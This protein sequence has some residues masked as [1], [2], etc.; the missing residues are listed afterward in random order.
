MLRL[1]CI[2]FCFLTGC[3]A[4]SQLTPCSRAKAFFDAF[5]SMAGTSAETHALYY[6]ASGKDRFREF[7]DLID[8]YLDSLLARAGTKSFAL[9]WIVINPRLYS[10][11]LSKQ[12][13]C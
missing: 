9:W 5:P 10:A 6:N 1:L 13:P 11:L 7:N 8:D 3:P 2:A 12:N 4:M